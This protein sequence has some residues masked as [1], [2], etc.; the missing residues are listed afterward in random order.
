M[1]LPSLV[2]GILVDR[3]GRG[4]MVVAAGGTLLLAGITAATVS[5]NSL[6]GLVIAL[7]LLGLGWNMGLISG[8]A[9]VIDATV[10]ATRPRVQGTLDVLVALAGAGGGAL[11]GVVKAQ[12]DYATLALGG[13]CLAV[14]LLPVVLWA[15][16]SRHLGVD[17]RLAATSDLS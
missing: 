10:P 8:T 4:P 6:G 15:Q 3:V 16:R 11:S 14:L 13:G 12:T 1:Y 9:L 17:H 7:C 5:G 2:T